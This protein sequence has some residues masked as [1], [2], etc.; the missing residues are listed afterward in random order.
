MPVTNHRA[1]SWARALIAVPL[2]QPKRASAR[3]EGEWQWDWSA[4]WCTTDPGHSLTVT[5]HRLSR[6]TVLPKTWTINVA[7]ENYDKETNIISY[8]QGF[9]H[10]FSSESLRLLRENIKLLCVWSQHSAKDTNFVWQSFYEGC[11]KL[12][13]YLI[14]GQA[15]RSGR[16]LI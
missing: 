1:M 14:L 4:G 12:N 3:G 16:S 13:Y 11:F 15:A 6:M 7:T 10:K 8:P 5:L 2:Q 9:A